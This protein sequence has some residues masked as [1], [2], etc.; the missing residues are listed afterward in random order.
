MQ[1]KILTREIAISIETQT[2]EKTKRITIEVK[3]TAD[4]KTH[5]LF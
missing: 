4:I 5:V 1:A 2:L 3:I